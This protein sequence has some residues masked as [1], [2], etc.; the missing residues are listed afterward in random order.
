VHPAVLTGA[1]HLRSTDRRWLFGPEVKCLLAQASIV[2]AP[3]KLL[4][5]PALQLDGREAEAGYRGQRECAGKW[6]FDVDRGSMD[7]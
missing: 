4:L 1:P 6:S 5:V 3:V 2:S 7:R